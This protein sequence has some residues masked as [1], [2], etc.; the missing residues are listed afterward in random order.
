M[1]CVS[2]NDK[3]VIGFLAFLIV[4]TSVAVLFVLYKIYL[5]KRE[6]SRSV[7]QMMF[8]EPSHVWL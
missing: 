4:P 2:D 8:P 5:L 3:A 7:S 1:W 6:K